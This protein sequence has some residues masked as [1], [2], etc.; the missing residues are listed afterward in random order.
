MMQKMNVI[1]RVI[2][3]IAVAWLLVYGLG[4]TVRFRWDLT[5][6]KRYSVSEATREVLSGLDE[7]LEVEILLTGELPGGMR[8]FQKAI[9]ET[10]KTFDAFSGS[11]IRFFYQNPLDL[12][13]DIQQEYI[14]ALADY[15]ITPTNLFASQQGGQ[16]SRLIFP[17]IV[18]RNEDFEV[19]ALLLKGE[20]G[21]SPD[22]ILN[23]SI[24]NLEFE[25]GQAIKRLVAKYQRSVGLI[26]GHGEMA[27]D[28][29]YGLVEAL[30]DDFEVYK[31][32][33]EQA[34]KVEDLLDFEALIIAGPRESFNEREKFLLD[35]YLMYGGNLLF[36]ID[37]MA[38]NLEDA[39][40]DGTVAMPFDAGLDDLL[41]RYGIRINR[42]LIQDLNF[43]YHPVVA[44]DFGDQSQIVPLPWPFYVMAGRMANHPITKGLDQV[45]FRFVS[46]L[47]TVKAEGVRKIPLIF[48]SDYTRRLQAPVRVAFEDMV[49]EPDMEA[50][51]L[52]RL[53]LAYLLEGSFT[54]YF[55]NRLLPE[56][57]EQENF[58]DS[59]DVGRVLVVGDG[60]FVK[61]MLN[62]ISGEPLVLGEDPFGETALANR[63]FLQHA[64]QYLSDPEGIIASRTK[65]YQIRP[66]NR[67][68]SR[69]QHAF[70][71]LINVVFPVALVV[72]IG[73][74]RYF[75]RKQRYEKP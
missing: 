16:T 73:F 43:G 12:P 48:S 26:M 44:G 9:E 66:L 53:P 31:V 39:G 65:Q 72:G 51:N 37:Q 67:V 20:R 55:K 59:G 29:G 56:G 19:G 69:N 68:K 4:E 52:S 42:D 54:S 63:S 14:L 49:Q 7:P 58:L 46:S 60:G 25:M 11:P 6:E 62:P 1:L 27:V 45:Q 74:V 33:L 47:D 57:F 22:E 2:L 32:P 15:G 61:S 34:N 21:M 23:H 5:E 40:G 71:Q 3:T 28:E 13:S 10:V 50:F 30:N 41:F 35:Q 8:R 17:G 64:L 70:W 75:L 18:V 24:E 36:F 38:V